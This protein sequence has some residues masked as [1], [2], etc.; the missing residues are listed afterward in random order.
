MEDVHAAGG[1]SAILRELARRPG[2]LHTEAKTV[3]GTTLG[4]AIT[5]AQIANP[6]CIRPLDRA[7]AARGALA[8]LFGSLAP[9]GAVVKVGAVTPQA[10]RFTGP[11]RVFDGEAAATAAVMSGTIDPGTVVVV[12]YEGPRGGPGMREMLALTSLLQGMALGDQ[13][14]L[15]TDGRFSG[16]TRGLCIGHLSPEAAE[17]GPIGL[18]CDGDVI[19][20]DLAARRLDVTLSDTELARRRQRYRPPPPRYL[21]GWLSRY[22]RLVSN[23]SAGAVLT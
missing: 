6:D 22:A 12:R 20:I 17:G 13:I 8:A 21:R 2:L 23:A 11:A 9:E 3:L 19:E 18:L 16:G 1:V 7:H 15:V 4:A 10:M 5:H 14:A